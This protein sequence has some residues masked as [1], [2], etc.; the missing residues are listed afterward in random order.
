MRR[1]K[2]FPWNVWIQQAMW[3]VPKGRLTPKVDRYKRN[4]DVYF[5]AVKANGPPPPFVFCQSVNLSR[6]ETN[7]IG[8]ALA[9]RVISVSTLCQR[10][11]YKWS[12]WF[13]DLWVFRD[14]LK[15][16]KSNVGIIHTEKHLFGNLGRQLT[17]W[18]CHS[19]T[20][21]SWNK[22]TIT[23]DKMI[24]NQSKYREAKAIKNKFNDNEKMRFTVIMTG[25]S[26]HYSCNNVFDYNSSFVLTNIIKISSTINYGEGVINLDK[27]SHLSVFH[28][29]R[30]VSFCRQAS[31]AF[32]ARAK[33]YF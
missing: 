21:Q 27:F 14:N 17:K 19:L 16:Q 24:T 11:T 4:P 31:L 22:L 7:G 10:M 6:V 5:S 33:V 25:D 2:T 26:H 23:F 13:W 18:L 12:K 29:G 32:Q 9:R 20:S 8:R 3:A 30:G 1:K 15:V 28:F